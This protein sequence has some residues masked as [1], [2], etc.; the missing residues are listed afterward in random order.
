MFETT[1]LYTAAMQWHLIFSNDTGSK[2]IEP[3]AERI[4]ARDEQRWNSDSVTVICVTG[5]RM[6]GHHGITENG[7]L[8]SAT[9]S[10]SFLCHEH[11]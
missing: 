8:P 10:A 6:V 11:R 7:Q 3:M 1:G 4:L 2:P 9:V 5:C